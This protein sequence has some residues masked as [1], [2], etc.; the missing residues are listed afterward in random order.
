MN[1]PLTCLCSV[2]LSGDRSLAGACPLLM[3]H[4]PRLVSVSWAQ[5][6]PLQ[7]VLL[8]LSTPSGD[9]S[10]NLRQCQCQQ[11]RQ[12]PRQQQLLRSLQRPNSCT[13]GV[14][15]CIL[16]VSSPQL[17]QQQFRK[18]QHQQSDHQTTPVGLVQQLAA[19]LPSLPHLTPCLSGLWLALT[20]A[21]FQLGQQGSVARCC[22]MLCCSPWQLLPP[23]EE[24][25]THPA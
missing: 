14:R 10:H 6:V 3:Q 22:T 16:A 5:G 12:A 24:P 21:A 25:D 13:W 8:S 11:S 1:P 15:E 2:N 7:R 20:A 17:S 23:L 4:L 9:A 19:V 18:C